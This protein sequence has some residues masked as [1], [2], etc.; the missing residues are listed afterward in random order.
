MTEN[1]IKNIYATAKDIDIKSKQKSVDTQQYDRPRFLTNKEINDIVSGIAPIVSYTGIGEFLRESI[2]KKQKTKLR[3]VNIVPVGIPEFKKKFTQSFIISVIQAG[4]TVGLTA[5]E[6]ISA[7]VSQ[8][9]FNSF[10]NAGRSKNMIGGIDGFMETLQVMSRKH[11]LM[12]VY[13]K[14]NVTVDD[15]LTKYTDLL[16]SVTIETCI[17]SSIIESY[18]ILFPNGIKDSWYSTYNLYSKQGVIES[19]Y[20]VRL[21]LNLESMYRYKIKPSKIVSIIEEEKIIKCYYS[22]IINYEGINTIIMDLYIE[23]V[24]AIVNDKE[25]VKSKVPES[26]A[27]F[28]YFQNIFIPKLRHIKIKGLNY[29]YDIEPIIKKIPLSL[30][31]EYPTERYSLN[32][33]AGYSLIKLNNIFMNYNGL[34]VSNIMRLLR[35]CGIDDVRELPEDLKKEFNDLD[36]L[37]KVPPKPNDYPSGREY[38]AIGLVKFRI[39]Q[40]EAETKKFRTEQ[41]KIRQDITSDANKKTAEERKKDIIYANSIKIYKQPSTIY[42]EANLIYAET[43]GSDFSNLFKLDD[44]D[45]TRSYSNIMSETLRYFG[46]EAVRNYIIRDL[47][48]LVQMS[49]SYIDPRHPSVVADWMTM[50]GIITPLTVKGMSKHNLGSLANASF[51]GPYEATK[52]DIIVNKSDSLVNVSASI[53]LGLPGPIGTGLPEILP[54]LTKIQRIIKSRS[55]TEKKKVSN[56]VISNMIR[57]LESEDTDILDQTKEVAVLEPFD[58]QYLI[59]PMDR[60]T[61]VPDTGGSTLLEQFNIFTSYQYVSPELKVARNSEIGCATPDIDILPLQMKA[62]TVKSTVRSEP[63]NVAPIVTENLKDY[64]TNVETPP[65]IIV[66]SPVS[67]FED[68]F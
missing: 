29:I 61:L 45:I 38:S 15:I 54:D 51:R 50:F 57:L 9:A 32:E 2:I 67:S 27:S 10:H 42:N 12:N 1:V 28:F 21:F 49:D 37:V 40:D 43:T 31:S 52:K 34:D 39:E 26:E 14:E 20:V 30:Y 68:L 62:E 24:N 19:T 36:L 33:Y 35:A 56:S 17:T 55:T 7:P 53:A 3:Q 18:Y 25:F 8:Q 47:I 60:A 66:M 5:A 23:N 65:E 46:I 48:V 44:V 13:F 64:N 41:K 22:P 11:P 58:S 59:R 4:T 16:V 63:L 6:A